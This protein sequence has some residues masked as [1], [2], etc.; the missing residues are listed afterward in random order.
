MVEGNVYQAGY[1]ELVVRIGRGKGIRLSLLKEGGAF[2]GIRK[3]NTLVA[4]F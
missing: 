1:I 3:R 4:V 2:A